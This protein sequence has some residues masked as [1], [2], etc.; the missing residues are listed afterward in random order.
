MS[1]IDDGEVPAAEVAFTV[2]DCSIYPSTSTAWRDVHGATQDHYTDVRN[3]VSAV[4]DIALSSIEPAVPLRKHVSQ[5]NVM[6]WAA[7]DLWAC[8]YPAIL[9][10]NKSYAFQVALIVGPA[11]AEFCFCLGAGTGT[12][13][14]PDRRT[15]NR[16]E[17]ERAQG[18]LPSLPQQAR[19][20][21]DSLVKE[22]YAFRRKWRAGAGADFD[23]LDDWIS[24]A[25]SSTGQGASISMYLS[26]HDLESLGT[27][28]IEAFVDLARVVQPVFAHVY[29]PTAT[30]IDDDGDAGVDSSASF[31]IGTLKEYAES[32]QPQLR[33][34]ERVYA[35]VI[36]AL[37][38][39]KNVILTGPPGTAKTTLALRIAEL[40]HASGRSSGHTLTTATADWTTYETIGGLRPA[41]DGL[42]F[43]EGHF[44][45][46]IRQNRWLII[47]ELN[48]SNFDRAFGQLFTVLAGQ[49][50]TLPY[51][52]PGQAERLKIS[53]AG[54][55]AAGGDVLAMS[56]SWRIV[57]TMNVFDKNLLFEM[58]YALMRRFAFIEV[59]SPK[60]QE[61]LQLLET[62]SDGDPVALEVAKSLFRL[63]SIRDLGP[64]IFRDAIA[65]ARRRVEASSTNTSDLAFEC[66][67]SYFLP[68]FEGVDD[69]EGKQLYKVL[70][71]E[72]GAAHRD[73]LQR[74]L[75]AVLGLTDFRLAPTGGDLSAGPESGEEADAPEAE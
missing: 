19:A 22:G 59:P 37:D 26:P 12:E 18:R 33:L 2:A 40:A 8:L 71:G 67:Y 57:A 61:F 44:L 4:M 29:G 9:G 28:V 69:R 21:L 54:D 6:S 1:T 32:K 35:R 42:E 3:K 49:P 30:E 46:A 75:K 73:E 31:D 41:N 20:A 47:D 38:S 51:V 5:R 13:D 34:D 48:R 43:G 10:R 45:E 63:R 72:V 56:A 15:K 64:A 74:V 7:R 55:D 27:G 52:R 58:S 16:A 50:V 66:F 14:D 24:W 53:P 11:G 68:Q 60:D 39:G 62:W 36:A 23:G 25:S 65:Y 70:L 17:F